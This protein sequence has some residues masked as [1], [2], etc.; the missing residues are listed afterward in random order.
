MAPASSGASTN[1]GSALMLNR[2]AMASPPS[3]RTKP[4]T[5]SSTS[6]NSRLPAVIA[7]LR[8]RGFEF[9]AAAFRALEEERRKLQLRT[10]ELQGRRNTLSKQV[11]I[12]K[13]KGEDASAVLGEV[14]HG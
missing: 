2:Q 9:D 11:G 7:G 14:D 6:R 8:R 12:L 5:G 3:R 4:S 1:L 10:E 13:G